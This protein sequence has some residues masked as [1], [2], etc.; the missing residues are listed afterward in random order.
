[1]RIDGINK[2]RSYGAGFLNYKKYRG[3]L[4][5]CTKIVNFGMEIAVD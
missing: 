2:N 3:K 5:N 1:M 4:Q